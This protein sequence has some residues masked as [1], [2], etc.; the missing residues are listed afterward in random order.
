MFFLSSIYEKET[1]SFQQ[2]PLV[3][4]QQKEDEE[5]TQTEFLHLEKEGEEQTQTEFLHLEKGRGHFLTFLAS[6]S[7]SCCEFFFSSH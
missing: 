5:Q 3:G 4:F 1:Y 2:I 7:V 6:L